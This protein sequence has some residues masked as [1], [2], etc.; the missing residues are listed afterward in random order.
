M[1]VTNAR[2]T[3]SLS[4]FESFQIIPRMPM[5]VALKLIQKYRDSVEPIVPTASNTFVDALMSGGA[6]ARA[7]FARTMTA[8][9]KH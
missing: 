1:V 5:N 7:C 9:Y 4:T 2:L 8:K 6:R 3:Q